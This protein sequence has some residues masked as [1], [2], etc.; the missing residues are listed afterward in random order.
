M[1]SDIRF[2]AVAMGL[3]AAVAAALP[4]TVRANDSVQCAA[5][6]EKVWVYHSPTDFNV[7]AKLACGSGITIVSRVKGYVEIRTAAGQVGYVPDDAIPNLPPY[8]DQEAKNAGTDGG[9]SLGDI[10]KRMRHGGGSAESA[11]NAAPGADARGVVASAAAPVAMTAPVRP[12]AATVNASAPTG[13]I[14]SA[15]SAARAATVA[16]TP[17]SDSAAAADGQV[18][19]AASSPVEITL[20]NAPDDAAQP[21]AVRNSEVAPSAA[22]NSRRKPGVSATKRATATAQPKSIAPAPA[23]NTESATTVRPPAADAISVA[24]VNTATADAVQPF[25]KGT[26]DLA[27]PASAD[28]DLDDDADI[29]PATVNARAAC[30]SYFSAYGL[31]PNQYKW[32]ETE[33]KKKYPGICPAPQPAL[34]DFVVIFTHDVNFYNYTMPAPVRTDANGLSDWEP[35]RM[36]DTAYVSPSDADKNRHEYVWVFHTKR[37]AFDP[38]RFSARRHPQF[39]KSESNTFGSHAGDRTAEDALRFIEGQGGTGQ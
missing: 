28:A 38:A 30:S 14:A 24:A 5:N 20:T 19:S 34:V 27:A 11:S 18:A 26:R 35:M 3:G 16:S 25:A 8:V 10:A 22:A 6:E 9:M 12:S 21:V 39:E 32:I 31:T 4:A 17:V 15:R 23:V 1:R 7:E 37:G 2:L 33:R 36:V 13:M 29:A